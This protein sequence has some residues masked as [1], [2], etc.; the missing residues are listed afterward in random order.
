M[1]AEEGEFPS[2][3]LQK[4]FSYSPQAHIRFFD[5][6]D[7]PET[8]VAGQLA[9]L[10][11]GDVSIQ[12]FPTSLTQVSA[13]NTLISRF[14][15]N[16]VQTNLQTFSGFY[17]RYYRSTT[18]VESAQWLFDRVSAIISSSGSTRATVRK[19]T[20]SFSQFSVV[21]TIP[22]TSAK[23]VVVGAHQDS[24]NIASATGRAP[25]ADDDGS[26]S[27]AILEAFRT[28]LTDSRI[29]GGQAPNTIE[30]HWYAGE[31]AGLLGSQAIFQQYASQGKVVAAML[32]QDMVGYSPRNQFGVITD[33]TN[34]ALNTFVKRVID[35]YASIGYV[36]STCGYACSDHASATRSGYPASFVFEA[37][38]ANSNPA[39]HQTT[40]TIDRVNF[41]HVNEHGKLILGFLTELA[42]A[43]SI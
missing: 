40:D 15:I 31:E 5:I 29:S 21:A 23:T 16:T 25:G 42:F 30:F 12:A 32:N 9:S 4:A 6:T 33:N 24:I 7:F 43:A 2:I 26:G 38:F 35:Q 34:A 19:V 41:A 13:V 11:D 14:N 10:A 37:A 18:G 39:I 28:I 20:H 36:E 3:C 22:G 27:M 17:N 8:V 1:G